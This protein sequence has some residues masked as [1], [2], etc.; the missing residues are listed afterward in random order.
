MRGLG[1][2]LALVYL[3]SVSAWGYPLT[4]KPEQTPGH[5]C[6]A[7]NSDFK[8]FRYDEKIPYCERNVTTGRKSHIYQIYGIP[9]NCKAR[10][11]ID[12]LI[13]LALGGS[14]EESNLWPEHKLVKALRPALETQLYHEILAGQITQRDAIREILNAKFHPASQFETAASGCDTQDF[15]RSYEDFDVAEMLLSWLN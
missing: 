2:S 9:K 15:G 13:P 10:F 4:P 5:L 11:T 6:T 3:V 12:H 14:N 1:W 7:V 8:E